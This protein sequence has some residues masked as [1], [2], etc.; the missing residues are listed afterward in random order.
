[1]KDNHK[2][3]KFT[4]KELSKRFNITE[5]TYNNWKKN[6]PALIK[7]IELGLDFEDI[8]ENYNNENNFNKLIKN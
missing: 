1:M 5:Q 2:Y 8:L 3:K 4:N 7:I 6:K